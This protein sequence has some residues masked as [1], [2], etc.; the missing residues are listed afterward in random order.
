MVLVEGQRRRGRASPNSSR[1]SG[2]CATD[3]GVPRQQTWPL[4]QI[5]V[6]VSAITTCRSCEISRMPQLRLVADLLDQIVE[7]HLA[8]EVDALHRL[9]E[10]QQVGLAGSW[11]APAAPAGTRRP[12]GAAPRRRARCAMPTASSAASISA[13]A[14][15]AP[16]Q[17]HQ[18]AHRQ[19]QR[20]VDGELLR[21]IA[22]ASVR[23]ARRPCPRVGFSTPV[24][25]LAVVDLP[26][27]FGPISVTI[28]PAP[29]RQIDALAPASGRRAA[30]RR[31]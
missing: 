21:H 10:H 22:D 24:T 26:E 9:V 25:S 13:P 18:P 6:S 1:Y 2:L 31:R 11:R 27:P 29:D 3:C 12:T 4:R 7:R 16:G 15:C 14:G 30:R 5:T 8:G 17:R 20:P 28:S 23:A 19:R